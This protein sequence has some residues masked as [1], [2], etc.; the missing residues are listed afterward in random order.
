VLRQRR[1]H[2]S[3]RKQAQTIARPPKEFNQI[4]TSPTENKN[5]T[6]ERIFLEGGLHHPTQPGE[7]R[8]RSVIPAAIQMRIPAGV[9]ASTTNTGGKESP[10]GGQEELRGPGVLTASP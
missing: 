8:R 5:M 6:R 2:F 10:R 3:F 9:L 4:P 7:T 1:E